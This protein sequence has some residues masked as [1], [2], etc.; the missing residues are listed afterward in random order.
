MNSAPRLSKA[1]AARPLLSGILCLALLGGC[2][3]PANSPQQSVVSVTNPVVSETQAKAAAEGPGKDEKAC[4][5]CGGQGEAACHGPG[6]VGGKVSCPAPCIKLNTGTWAKHP[7]LHRP[8]PNELMQLVMVQG[9]KVLV[10][11]HHE[12]VQYFWVNGQA[13]MRACPTCG[14][15][16]KVNCPVC[17]GLGRQ[18][19]QICSGKKFIP[20][21]WTPTDNPWFN[22]QPDLIRLKDG[23]VVLG[24]IA[25]SSGDDRTIVTRDKKII[26]AKAGDILPKSVTTPPAATNVPSSKP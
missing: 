20:I 18:T 16:A 23:Q 7:E 3:K 17:K 22:R 9:H 25:L 13:E 19:C 5:G 4:F 12:G 8:D 1:L 2:D 26:H 24:R 6:C 14:G 15:T 21:A 10:S 11:S